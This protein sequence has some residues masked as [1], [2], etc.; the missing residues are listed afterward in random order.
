MSG[1][2]VGG[3]EDGWGGE[4]EVGEIDGEVKVDNSFEL[5]V[6]AWAKGEAMSRGTAGE[7]CVAVVIAVVMMVVVVAG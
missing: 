6:M 7:G 4:D 5:A 3:G 2:G 1:F